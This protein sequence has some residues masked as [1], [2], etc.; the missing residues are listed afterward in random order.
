MQYQKII[1]ELLDEYVSHLKSADKEFHED[2]FLINILL[3]LQ[4]VMVKTKLNKL[5]KLQR[6]LL[7]YFTINGG[8]TTSGMGVSCFNS[9]LPLTHPNDIY[10]ALLELIKIGYLK[11]TS[12]DVN[13]VCFSQDGYH[14]CQVKLRYK[15]KIRKFSAKIKSLTT[16]YLEKIIL[17]VVSAIIAS[18]V[19]YYSTTLTCEEVNKQSSGS[20]T[21]SKATNKP[22]LSAVTRSGLD[23]QP[24]NW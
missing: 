4:E 10:E 23:K 14:E 19:T 5:S 22:N 9:V 20:E 24:K 13:G 15:I 11:P 6:N 8:G 3:G 18:L 12:E 2:S 17:I 7:I 21:G 1:R 16:N